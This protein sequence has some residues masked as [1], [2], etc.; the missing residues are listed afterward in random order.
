[1]VQ[2]WRDDQEDLPRKQG[3]SKAMSRA[4]I[5]RFLA[6]TERLS[7]HALRSLPPKADVPVELG[8]HREVCAISRPRRPAA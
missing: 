6:H 5:A 4:D 8:S 7:H 2:S 3:A 1:V